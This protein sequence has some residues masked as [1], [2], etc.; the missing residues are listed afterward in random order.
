MK[1][2]I[3]G[4]RAGHWKRPFQLGDRGRADRGYW[5]VAELWVL[6]KKKKGENTGGG[7]RGHSGP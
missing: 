1:R 3:L 6:V 2:K 7:R 4:G 5:G